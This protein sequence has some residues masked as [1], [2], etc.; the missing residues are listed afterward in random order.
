M[1]RTHGDKA[2]F[3]KE[4][5]KKNLRRKRIQE[6]KK[7]LFLENKKASKDSAKS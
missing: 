2:R 7:E 1:S 5:K 6:L 3:G 4:R